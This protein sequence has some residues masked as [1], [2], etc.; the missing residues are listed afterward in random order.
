[1]A[2]GANASLKEANTEAID[3]T[4]A[5]VAGL[6]HSG[7]LALQVD[8]ASIGHS[9]STTCESADDG[10]CSILTPGIPPERRADQNEMALAVMGSAT[11]RS[12]GDQLDL[13]SEMPSENFK[14]SDVERSYGC[15]HVYERGNL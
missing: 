4:R 2:E 12:D 3:A 9:S 15:V 1:M 8:G 6:G 10:K 13:S 7:S 11:E 5:D 14:N